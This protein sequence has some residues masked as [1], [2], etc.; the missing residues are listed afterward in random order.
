MELTYLDGRRAF[1]RER[2]LANFKSRYAHLGLD[3]VEQVTWVQYGFGTF[4]HMLP[5]P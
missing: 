1:K 3:V 4:I 5:I 2:L